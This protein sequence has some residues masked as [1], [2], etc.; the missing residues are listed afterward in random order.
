MAYKNK[1]LFKSVSSVGGLVLVLLILVLLNIIFFQVNVRYDATEDKLY[2]LS[3]GTK[4][5]LSNLDEDVIIKVFYSKKMVNVPVHIKAY[6]QRVLDFLSEYEHHGNGKLSVEIHNTEVDSE[7]EEWAQEYGINGINL[8]TGETLYFGL[9]AM[10]ADQEETIAFMD[11]SGEA[12]LEYDITRIIS[13]VQSSKKQKIAIIA[14]LPVFGGAQPS[15]NPQNQNPALS[16]WLFVSELNKTYDVVKVDLNAEKI[17]TDTDLLVIVHPAGLSEKIQYAVDQYVLKGGNLIVFADPLATVDNNNPGQSLPMK[18]LFDAWGVTLNTT[19]A[20]VDFDLSTRLRTRDNRI[21]DNPFWISAGPASFNTDNIITAKLES[22]LLPI[23]GAIKKIPESPYEF[24]PLV[25]SSTNC[26]LVETFKARFGTNTIRHEF[27]PSNEKYNLAVKISGQFKTAFPE[28]KPKRSA[29]PRDVGTQT[30]DKPESPEKDSGNTEEKGLKQ[31][32]KKATIV[33]VA[34]TD[35]LFDD[36]YVDQQNFLGFNMARI[37][38]D[39]LNFLLNTGEMLTGSEA[40]I[41][42]RS[43]G[44]FE[45]PFTRVNALEKK[46]QMRWLARERELVEKAEETNRKLKELEQQKNASQKFIISEKQEAEIN[47]F[48]SKKQEINRQLKEVRRNLRASIESLGSTIKFINLFFIPLLVGIG[49]IVF[50][51]YKQKKGLR[52]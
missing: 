50:A 22:M 20:V 11:P 41:S 47:K 15:F 16:P 9:V 13:R 7:E 52:S 23:A 4:Q 38:N 37:F 27:S 26:Q 36:Y 10:A 48:Q 19:R 12:H 45:R 44:K 3:E 2:S 6:A 40:L 42:I 5:I 32:V 46:A 14:G 25:Q 43:Q 39:N 1:Y 31:G 28:G 18:K 34:D 29:D 49:G 51:V 35:M 17:E 30:S 33:I 24:E 21:E 8:T